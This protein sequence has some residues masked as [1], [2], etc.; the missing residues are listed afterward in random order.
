MQNRGWTTLLLVFFLLAA[1]A[2]AQ[3]ASNVLAVWKVGSPYRTDAPENSV[4]PGLQQLAERMGLQIQMHV[5]PAQGFAQQFFTAFATHQEPDILAIEN[6]GVMSGIRTSLGEFPALTAS[7]VVRDSLIDVSVALQEIESPRGGWEYLLSTSANYKAA[8]LLALRPP[9]C[10]STSSVASDVEH[11]SSH[12]VDQ[13]LENPQ[14]VKSEQDPQGVS[15]TVGLQP[16]LKPLDTKICGAWGNNHLTFVSASTNFESKNYIGQV[17]TLLVLRREEADWK[18]IVASTDPISTGR[19]LNVVPA[20]GSRL[21]GA[22]TTG[23]HP[24]PAQLFS[25]ND[26]SRPAPPPGERFGDFVWQPSICGGVVAE[27]AEFSSPQDPRLVLRLG[28]VSATTDHVSSGD[29][30]SNGSLWKWRIWSI[31][32]SGAIAF[33]ESREFP[34]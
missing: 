4:S 11:L 3:Q 28:P 31:D 20:L 12:L 2:R 30:W 24:Q 13:F 32:S 6:M 29:I 21:T 10:T 34:N 33:S 27:I 7:P 16:S 14:S 26:G 9:E 1:T 17:R 18:L 19:F 5:F 8:R 15:V 25:P 23:M 22:W